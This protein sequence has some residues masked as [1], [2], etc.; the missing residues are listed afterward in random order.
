M[1][2]S[3]RAE[4]DVAS[5][6]RA[7]RL[8]ASAMIVLLALAPALLPAL[9]AE[10]H[11]QSARERKLIERGDRAM[12]EGDF[13]AASEHYRE[14]VL[15][16]PK[17]GTYRLRFGTALFAIGRYSYASFSFRRAVA[18]LGYADDLWVP[19]TA[20][21]GDRAAYERARRDLEVYLRYYPTDPHGLS[22]RAFVAFMDGD[23][24]TARR[25]CRL[26]L[27]DRD[28]DTFAAYLLRRVELLQTPP[29]QRAAVVATGPNRAPEP[30]RAGHA[31]PHEAEPPTPR[32]PPTAGV[33]VNETQPRDNI[34]HGRRSDPLDA[35]S[36]PQTRGV[37]AR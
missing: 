17:N 6:T 25:D 27:S 5:R 16:D 32:K 36:Q 29:W 33:N 4:S 7:A 14:A 28:E 12:H 1:F 37:L 15:D 34:S 31:S 19:I 22:V 20:R 10:R 23:L 8:P 18:A 11:E 3:P 21:F 30:N 13:V 26:L 2:R 35:L 9:A 24:E